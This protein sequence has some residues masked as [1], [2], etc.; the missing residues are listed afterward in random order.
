MRWMLVLFFVL[1]ACSQPTERLS[2]KIPVPQAKPSAAMAKPNWDMRVQGRTV[3]V[4]VVT[5]KSPGPWPTVMLLHGASGLGRGYMI[6][7][8]AKA[9]ADRG[10]A[11][12]VVQYFDA[13]P[14]QI[15]RKGAVRYFEKREVQLDMMVNQLLAQPQVRGPAIGVY[16]YSLGG[17]HGLALAGTDPRVAAVV[18]LG[19]G[20]PRHVPSSNLR[21]AS[22]ALVVHGR[23]D[24]IVPFSRALETVTA[25]KRYKRPIRLMGLSKTGHVPR[26]ADRD[27]VIKASADFLAKELVL[28]LALLR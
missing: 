6:W 22:P 21:L 25:W 9:L 16:G 11:A 2:A 24:R 14:K 5:P 26:G 4:H 23:R 13:M 8:V 10:V 27:R 1:A 17:F 15:S 7:P 28:Q 12:A 19:G 3:K 18:S 20:L